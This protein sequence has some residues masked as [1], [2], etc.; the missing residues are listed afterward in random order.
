M[1]TYSDGFITS[2]H[3]HTCVQIQVKASKG[4]GAGKSAIA[5]PTPAPTPADDPGYTLYGNSQ[6]LVD[7]YLAGY[8]G[9]SGR[10][11][12]TAGE[13]DARASTCQALCSGAGFI[14]IFYFSVEKRENG[15]CYCSQDK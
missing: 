6:R 10:R 8:T 2:P 9:V 3:P 14:P 7:G 13:A 5:C 4:W 12:L 11:E 1:S 15:A